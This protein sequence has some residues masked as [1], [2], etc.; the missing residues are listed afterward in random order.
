MSATDVSSPPEGQ[1]HPREPQGSSDLSTELAL[2]GIGWDK[3]RWERFLNELT[4]EEQA[5]E[6][7]MLV[8]SAQAPPTSAWS[9]AL[10]ILQAALSVAGAVSGIGGAISAVQA[11][12][13]G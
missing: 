1:E 8:D 3:D 5:L 9:V 7:Q 11:V 13:K 10:K 2:T 6:V 12:A 4:P